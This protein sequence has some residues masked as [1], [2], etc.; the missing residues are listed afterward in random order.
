M[1]KTLYTI[2]HSTRSCTDFI[3]LLTTHKIKHL[4]DIRAF[5]K[6]ARFPWFNQL[7]LTKVL[8]EHQI[9]YTHL[10]A[11]GGRRQPQL[12][13]INTGLRNAG[14]RG[15][16]DYM[17]TAAFEAGLEQL[18][19]LFNR[20]RIAIMCAEGNPK[21][22]HRLLIADAEL[23]RGLI[24]KHI[25][26]ADELIEHVLTPFAVLHKNQVPVKIYYPD[27]R[28]QTHLNI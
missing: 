26:K 15:F 16:A 20:S 25:L 19:H 10:P 24:V 11:L 23:G 13:S 4:V 7:N 18:N 9:Q 14:F 2:G 28:F 3:N 22:C 27:N 6:S 17:Q 5:P 1:T 8:H 21:N 12:D